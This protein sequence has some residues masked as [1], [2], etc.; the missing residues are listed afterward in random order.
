MRKTIR[1]SKARKQSVA[2]L[3]LDVG[4]T[5]PPFLSRKRDS[6]RRIPFPDMLLL[7]SGIGA[8]VHPI[9]ARAEIRVGG[10]CVV[11]PNR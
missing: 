8:T 9:G 4:R 6:L 3:L 2:G 11:P 5:T 7:D 1:G 10:G